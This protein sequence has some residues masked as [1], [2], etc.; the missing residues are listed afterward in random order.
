MASS[1]VELVR[2]IYANWERGD[3]SSA[4]WAHPDIEFV[5][6]DGLHGSWT[7]LAGMAEGWRG[8]LSAWDDFRAEV[9]EYRDLDD[10]RVLV[11]NRFGGRGKTSGLDVAP[12]G[13]KGASV[14]H[15]R[16]GK[17]TRLA[18]YADRERA[19]ADLG[20]ARQH[21]PRRV[22]CLSARRSS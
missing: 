5:R 22:A 15:I 14:F 21:W 18:A 20:L 6:P 13:T 2:S 9:E 17:V 4:D 8:W 7:A 16:G 12:M 1:N 11:L 19:F 10:E 3:F